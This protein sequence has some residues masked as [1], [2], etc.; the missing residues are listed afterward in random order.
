M[1]APT[2]VTGAVDAASRQRV[3][4]EVL[5]AWPELTEC[6]VATLRNRGELVMRVKARYGLSAIEAGRDV[7]RVLKGRPF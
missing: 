1:N 2:I 7:D 5:A 4:Q 6:G 3:L